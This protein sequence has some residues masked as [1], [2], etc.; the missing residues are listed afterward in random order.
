MAD[1]T[2]NAALPQDPEAAVRARYAVGQ[3]LTAP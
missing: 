2:T 1:R 3:D